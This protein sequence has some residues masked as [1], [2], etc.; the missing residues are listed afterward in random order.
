MATRKKKTRKTSKAS[1]RPAPKRKIARKVP[2][3]RK[4]TASPRPARKDEEE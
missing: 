4:A 3:V 2:G 1:K